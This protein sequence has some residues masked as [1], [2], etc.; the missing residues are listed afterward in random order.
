MKIISR[1]LGM[2]Q[3]N[4]YVL[5]NEKTQEAVVIDPGYG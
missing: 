2:W 3:T 4:F 5:A 1:P